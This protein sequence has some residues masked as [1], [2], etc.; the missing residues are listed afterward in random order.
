M[1]AEQLERDNIDV[2]AIFFFDAVA[3]HH[4]PG[5]E[6]IPANVNFSRHARRDLS[7]ILLVLKYEGTFADHALLPNSSNPMRPSFGNTGISWRGSG[8]HQTA[9]FVGS[10]GALG[11]VGWSFVT[12]DPH[13]QDQVA[14]WMNEQLKARGVPADLKAMQ[15]P[16]GPAPASP[17]AAIQLANWALDLLLIARHNQNLSKSGQI[18]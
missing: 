13:C 18:P 14:D 3:R 5:G 17:S 15:I 12:E 7:A 2:D 6:V 1:A 9:E 16:P 11:G 4:Y 10:H 8:D